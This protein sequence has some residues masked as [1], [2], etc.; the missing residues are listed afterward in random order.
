M[1]DHDDGFKDFRE[2][3]SCIIRPQSLIG[4]KFVDCTPT[5]PRAAGSEPPPELEEI[6]TASP[7]E[8]QRLLPLE[9]NGKAVDIDL[10]QNI[11]RVPYRDRFRLI[12]NDLG[13]GLAARGDDL[14]EVV[15]RAN[16]A[17][18]QTNRVLKILAEQNE[19]LAEPRQRRRR[20]ARAAR[21]RTATS[22]TGFFRNAGVAGQATAER[23]D[24]L[25]ARLE[26]FPETLREVRPD[27]ER[28]ARVR[29]PG[30][31]ADR[32][33]SAPP[34]RT[35]ARR[36]RSSARF[37][38]AAIPALDDPRRR[39]PRPRARSW[40]PPTRSIVRPRDLTDNTA[41][42]A[43]NLAALPRHLRQDQRLPVP[44]GLHLQLGRLDQRLRRR[45][46][47]SSARQ[48]PGHQLPGRHSRDGRSPAAR[49]SSR[50]DRGPSASARRRSSR[51]RLR[52][53]ADEARRPTSPPPRAESSRSST[54]TTTE[55][56][57]RAARRGADR[58]PP[59]RSP[60]PA[61]TRRTPTQDDAAAQAAAAGAAAQAAP[62]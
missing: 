15:D 4:E 49:R 11:N 45:S 58:G 20:R 2:D 43:K 44:D 41:P 50:R 6:A 51:R 40:S 9:N 61:P 23:G 31:A 10:I 35:S 30:H 8:G 33:T 7:G 52:I 59:P 1:N 24:D 37:A 18:R 55:P 48:H 56:P 42:A 29:R 38:R 16:P 19:Q 21:P 12:L 32:T 5:Q 25:E 17:L 13:A 36:P 28:P 46:A 54:P 27:D 3:A 57:S 47:T 39:R 62:S 26:K 60:T 14:G 53:Q 34:R 22:I